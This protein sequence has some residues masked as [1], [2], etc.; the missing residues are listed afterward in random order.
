M[1]VERERLSAWLPLA[2]MAFAAAWMLLEG[3]YVTFSSHYAVVYRPDGMAQMV[4]GVLLGIPVVLA[5]TWPRRWVPGLAVVL[6]AVA[7]FPPL[8]NNLALSHRYG[9][10]VGLKELAISAAFAALLA[11]A[12]VGVTR[13]VVRRLAE[14]SAAGGRP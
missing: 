14:A 2:P 13:F 6:S 7:A 10:A 1:T 9:W 5:R 12:C 8:W 3:A 4:A 11:V